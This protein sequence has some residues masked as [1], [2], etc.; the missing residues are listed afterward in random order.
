MKMENEEKKQQTVYNQVAWILN[1]QPTIEHQHNYIGGRPVDEAD[2][3]VAE[4]ADT[5]DVNAEEKGQEES[6]EELNFFAPSKNMKELLRQDWFKKARTK[7]EYDE[8]WTDGF[9]SALMESEWRVGIAKDWAV[10]GARN[11]RTQIKGYVVGLL[12]DAGVLKGSYDGIAAKVGLTDDPR[13]FSRYMGDG[14][15][16]P[17]AGWVKDYVSKKKR[18]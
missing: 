6:K 4:D 18:Q 8:Q 7:D 11:K 3:T 1:Y 15:N 2:D 13:S 12:K 17:Y 10:Q 5:E 14:K 9:V 16:Q